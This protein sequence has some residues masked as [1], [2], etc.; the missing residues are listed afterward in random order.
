MHLNFKSRKNIFVF[1]QKLLN[2]QD[3]SSKGEH[4]WK[5]R[6]LREKQT[7]TD[8]TNQSL[9]TK[10]KK[11]PHIICLSSCY[12]EWGTSPKKTQTVGFSG[13]LKKRIKFVNKKVLRNRI[14]MKTIQIVTTE[15]QNI[16]YELN[17]KRIRFQT[18]T[19]LGDTN[20]A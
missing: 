4:V 14:L 13:L 17:L 10:K 3:H 18:A 5:V 19:K 1:Y 6:N 8:K 15:C 12:T 20:Q 11:I 16:E 9:F 7:Q 2:S